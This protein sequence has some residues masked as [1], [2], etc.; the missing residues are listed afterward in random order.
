MTDTK[1]KS[2]KYVVEF[3][4]IIKR[5]IT[6]GLTIT[7]RIHFPNEKDAI[8]WV[9]DIQKIDKNYQFTDFKIKGVG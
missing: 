3:D 9:Q 7:D 1:T 2:F 5:G 6:N 4:K 8:A